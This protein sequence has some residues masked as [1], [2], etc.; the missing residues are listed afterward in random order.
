MQ[1]TVGLITATIRLYKGEFVYPVCKIWVQEGNRT[2]FIYEKPELSTYP[3]KEVYNQII[4]LLVKMV[5]YNQRLMRIEITEDLKNLGNHY[6]KILYHLDLC[7]QVC[8]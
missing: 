3:L 1:G 8:N 5:T 2:F 7:I 6:W 4:R